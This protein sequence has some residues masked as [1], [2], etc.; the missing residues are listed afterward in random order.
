M[1]NMN[2][3]NKVIYVTMAV[4][5]VVGLGVDAFAG[6]F[7]IWKFNCAM[8]VGV[9]WMADSRASNL[10]KKLNDIYDGRNK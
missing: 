10:E 8:W 3:L 2:T 6:K 1:K 7:E 4:T 5:L 9:A